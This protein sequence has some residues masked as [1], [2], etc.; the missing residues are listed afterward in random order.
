MKVSLIISFVVHV[1]IILAL[2][3]VLP[4]D[5]GATALQTY[6]VDLIRQPV[7]DLKIDDLSEAQIARIAQDRESASPS[8]EQDTISLDTKDKRYT[9]Y[10]RL[11][12]E[13]ILRQWRYPRKAK[14]Y[15]I[16]G[17]MTAVFSLI[18]Q[19]E[20]VK[21]SISET[22]GHEILDQEAIGAITRAAPFPPF[23][24]DITA[25]RLNIVAKFDYRLKAG[26]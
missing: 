25:K 22:S 10:T 5:L 3:K 20:M 15:L 18:E 21:I 9:S 6:R 8:E 13:S 1:F 26:K 14:E 24:E 11:I 23:P 7:E 16:E 2:Q 19:G 12:K 4:L 17:S